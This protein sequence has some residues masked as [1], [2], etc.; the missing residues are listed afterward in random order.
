MAEAGEGQL[1]T[2]D[3]DV[4]IIG[5]GVAGLSAALHLAE[6][7]IAPLLL[8]ADPRYPG[9]RLAGGEEVEV[10]GWRFRAEHGVHGLW[11]PYRNLQ[12]MLARHNLRP[13]L[14]PALE[15]SWYY[16]RRLE[17]KSAAVGSAIRHSWFPPPFHYLQ[18]FL[19]WR[20]LAILTLDD[21]LFLFQVWSGLLLAV[22]IDPFAEDQ[23]M[24]DI[25]LS[26]LV[27][28]WPDP[29][30][31]FFISLARNGLTARPDEIPLSGFIA[32]LRFYT[33]LRRDAWEF[34][35]LPENSGDTV[36][37]PLV[38]KIE[39]LGGRLRLGQRVA[40][41]EQEGSGWRVH[42]LDSSQSGQ[43][44]SCRAKSV[45]L[46]VDARSAQAILNA[47]RSGNAALGASYSYFPPSMETAV[48]RFWFSRA[49]QPGPEAGVFSGEFVTDNFFWLHRL[50]DSYHQWH[51]ATGGSALES[52]FYGPPELLA[53]SDAFL[54]AYAQREVLSAFPELR[55]SVIHRT[56]QRNPPAHTLLSLGHA[57]QHV[58]IETGWENLFC[59][60]DWVRHPTP[61]FFLERACVTGIEAANALLKRR[62]LTPWPLIPYLPPE[63]LARGIEWAMK[64]GRK[65]MRRKKETL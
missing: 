45:I 52:H 3:Q 37:D 30:R 20:F 31:S 58:G 33:L 2:A 16:Q 35:Y 39:S 32:F 11:S 46:A 47:S 54:L 48:A 59:C 63:T 6:R 60:G 10:N 65:L 56:F 26:D 41:L 64:A 57:D 8:E 40:H 55:G 44:L 9:G 36:I 12:A 61:A 27:Y 18:L 5:A 49:P 24:E 1:L 23:P 62:G 21:W 28:Y 50:Y 14:V 53:N 43:A 7:G 13:V 42:W 51:R 34:G 22:A 19:R 29:L 38:K 25:Y 4:V 15:E 17:I